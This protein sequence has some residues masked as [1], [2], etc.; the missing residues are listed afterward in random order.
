MKLKLQYL[1]LIFVVADIAVAAAAALLAAC[2]GGGGDAPT[3][4]QTQPTPGVAASPIPT[5]TGIAGVAGSSCATTASPQQAIYDL[6][7]AGYTAYFMIRVDCKLA[8][9]TKQNIA[10]LPIAAFKFNGN[11]EYGPGTANATKTDVAPEAMVTGTSSLDGGAT[12]VLQVYRKL[13][14]P[15]TF[16]ATPGASPVVRVT[17][18]GA[19]TIS[20]VGQ[21]GQGRSITAVAANVQGGGANGIDDFIG[22]GV[23]SGASR[24]IDADGMGYKATYFVT[25]AAYSNSS[26]SPA[27]PAGNLKEFAAV[28]LNNSGIRV[29]RRYC[30]YTDLSASN[31]G[32][33]FAGTIANNSI[34]S[35]TDASG[36]W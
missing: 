30:M 31:F 32:V 14:A 6:D 17:G 19:E 28:S 4:T 16:V 25:V 2:G 15:V 7:K 13:A 21:D 34:I 18:F 1:S 24:T 35:P 10:G 8:D 29:D 33:K 11:G 20:I 5:P 26:T 3:S 36:A 12:Y 22:G 9:G 23:M 27:C